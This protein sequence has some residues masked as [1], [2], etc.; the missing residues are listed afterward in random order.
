MDYRKQL[1]IQI[2]KARKEYFRLKEEIN[3]LMPCLPSGTYLSTYTSNSKASRCDVY[4]LSPYVYHVL[5]NKDGLLPSAKEANKPTYKHHLGRLH[6]ERFLK[7]VLALERMQIAK[8][9]LDSLNRVQKHLQ[10]LKTMHKKYKQAPAL[11]K[12]FLDAD[13]ATNEK[14]SIDALDQF[15]S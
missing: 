3:A 13:K 5:A 14:I 1:L 9:K 4:P 11:I 12:A 15:L 10:E 7:G 6:N 8:I 2:C